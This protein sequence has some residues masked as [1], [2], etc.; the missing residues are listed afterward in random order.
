MSPSAGTPRGYRPMRALRGNAKRS[1]AS[2]DAQ[3]PHGH[4]RLPQSARNSANPAQTVAPPGVPACSQSKTTCHINRRAPKNA[5]RA[6]TRRAPLSIA[7]QCAPDRIAQR[8]THMALQR[9]QCARN[10]VARFHVQTT[11]IGRSDPTYTMRTVKAGVKERRGPRW[12]FGRKTNF[13]HTGTMVP[14]KPT[15]QPTAKQTL[16]RASADLALTMLNYA[17]RL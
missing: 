6:P 3:A 16:Y 4:H 15:K 7:W 2:R 10:Y 11:Q 1:P 8:Q 12:N 5:P 9:F 14:M 13:C 17:F